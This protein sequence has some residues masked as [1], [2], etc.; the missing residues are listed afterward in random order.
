MNIVQVLVELL[1]AQ[2]LFQSICFIL[3]IWDYSNTFDIFQCI[4]T[5][6]KG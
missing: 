6:H 1:A 3:S 4:R 5:F 2:L